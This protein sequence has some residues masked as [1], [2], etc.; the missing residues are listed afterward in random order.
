[1]FSVR[2]LYIVLHCT[3]YSDVCIVCSVLCTPYSVFNSKYEFF[4]GCTTTLTLHLTIE[5]PSSFS[6]TRML[7][8]LNYH[9]M[10]N[11][12]WFDCCFH[13]DPVRPTLHY[14]LPR[15]SCQ[16]PPSNSCS[17]VGECLCVKRVWV[18]LYERECG[19]DIFSHE[20]ITRMFDFYQ[21]ISAVNVSKVSYPHCELWS[22]SSMILMPQNDQWYPSS[23]HE[24]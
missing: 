12:N 15:A 8:R 11:C 20:A 23:L 17:R 4:S 24:K 5:T 3:V 1:M 7:D 14:D 6:L 18:C 10:K 13:C 2:V 19:F 21:R 9:N 22:H 16:C